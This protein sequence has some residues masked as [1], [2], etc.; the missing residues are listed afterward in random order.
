MKPRCGGSSASRT[1]RATRRPFMLRWNWEIPWAGGEGDNTWWSR[2]AN[3]PPRRATL[4]GGRGSGLSAFRPEIDRCASGSPRTLEGT[5]SLY[6]SSHVED[7]VI[8][9]SRPWR[10]EMSVPADQ[11]AHPIPNTYAFVTKGEPTTRRGVAPLPGPARARLNSE[12]EA[13]AA[14]RGQVTDH[15]TMR[16]RQSSPAYGSVK[17]GEA[18]KPTARAGRG[19]DPRPMPATTVNRSDPRGAS[20]FLLSFLLRPSPVSAGS[21]SGPVLRA[22]PHDLRA[23]TWPGSVGGGGGPGVKG[24]KARATSVFGMCPVPRAPAPRRTMSASPDTAPIALMPA[25]PRLLPRPW[26]CEGAY[27]ARRPGAET[28]PRRD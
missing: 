3:L 13:A 2:A 27:Y 6:T 4:I 21:S 26:S 24:F 20:G 14:A 25:P 18:P 23:W 8:F 9:S 15:P 12:S 10:A 19:P 11:G 22:A 5:R 28:V 16:S 17:V 7:P 1:T